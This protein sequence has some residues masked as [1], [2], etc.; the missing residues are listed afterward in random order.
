[1]QDAIATPAVVRRA[2]EINGDSDNNDDADDVLAS[3][4]AAPGVDRIR[5]H[6]H[7]IVAVTGGSVEAPPVPMHG[8]AVDG[9]IDR[10]VDD[11]HDAVSGHADHHHKHHR[12]TLDDDAIQL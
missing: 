2:D 8:S 5:H 7:R 6:K 11:E 1:V 4:Q 12:V 10:F 9:N 3:P